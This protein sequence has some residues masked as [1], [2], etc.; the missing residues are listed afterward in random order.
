MLLCHPSTSRPASFCASPSH[1]QQRLLNTETRV[2]FSPLFSLPQTPPKQTPS[3]SLRVDNN[4][5]RCSHGHAHRFTHQP[6]ES[7]GADCWA[8]CCSRLESTSISDD[9]SQRITPNFVAT[10]INF[11]S[12]YLELFILMPLLHALSSGD[13]ERCV[14]GWY[15]NLRTT[16]IRRVRAVRSHRQGIP[17]YG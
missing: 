1:E 4:P 6:G 10:S 2:D 3:P 17:A 5:H 13:P 14:P 15:S 16:S 12:E 9:S 11:T 8:T 7:V